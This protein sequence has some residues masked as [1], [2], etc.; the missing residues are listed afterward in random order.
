M[1]KKSISS[2]FCLKTFVTIDVFNNIY[3]YHL[4][5]PNATN[6]VETTTMIYCP[7]GWFGPSCERECH[8]AGNEHC[9][10]VTGLCPVGCEEGW[11]GHSCSSKYLRIL[12]QRNYCV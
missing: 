8:C 3:F 11:G 4:S 5:D 9:H 1:L 10:V 2:V 12:L 6:S 7:L